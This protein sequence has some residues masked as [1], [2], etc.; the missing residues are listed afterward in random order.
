MLMGIYVQIATNGIMHYGITS[1]RLCSRYSRTAAAPTAT[2]SD[3][4]QPTAP[5]ITA[6]AIWRAGTAPLVV[7]VAAANVA[8]LFPPAILTVPASE[9]AD[10]V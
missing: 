5:G 10:A 1:P 8:L 6:V 2:A 9:P 4:M 7:C 3:R